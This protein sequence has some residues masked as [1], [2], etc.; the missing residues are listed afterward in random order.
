MRNTKN[1]VGPSGMT[2]LNSDKLGKKYDNDL[3]VGSYN[4]GLIFHFDLNSNRTELDLEGLLNDEIADSNKELENIIFSSGLGRITNVE[5]G[6]DGYL[7]VLSNYLNKAT[8]FR[9]VYT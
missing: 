1:T 4:L 3:F 7:Y 6:P 8:I 9:I 2:F 5:V